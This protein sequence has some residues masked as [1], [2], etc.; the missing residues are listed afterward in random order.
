LSVVALDHTWL[1]LLRDEVECSLIDNLV[2]DTEERIR[3]EDA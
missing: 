1:E 2:F 3:P